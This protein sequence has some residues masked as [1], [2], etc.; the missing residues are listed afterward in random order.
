MDSIILHS[1]ELSGISE[2]FVDSVLH[3]AA[4]EQVV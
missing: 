1:V 2:A 4:S 3:Y